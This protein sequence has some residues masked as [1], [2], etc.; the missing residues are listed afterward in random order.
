MKGTAVP[1]K[2]RKTFD[3]GYAAGWRSVIAGPSPG[4][5]AFKVPAGK[6]PYEHGYELGQKAALKFQQATQR[7]LN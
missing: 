6:T 5:L 3:A 7:R 4:V 2:P 1:K